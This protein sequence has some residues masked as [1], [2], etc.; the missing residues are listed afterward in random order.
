[1][2]NEQERVAYQEWAD[3]HPI[4]YA[5]IEYD[6]FIAGYQAGR[7]ALQSQYQEDAERYRY[8]VTKLQQA[9]DG[10]YIEIGPMSLYCY[11]QSQFKGDRVIRAEITWGDE[12]GESIGLSEAIDHAKRI[13]E[14]EADRQRRGEP[15]A[16][17]VRVGREEGRLAKRPYQTGDN[18]PAVGSYCLISGANCDIESDQHRGYFW[19][20]VLGYSDDREFVCLQTSGCWPTVERLTKCWFADIPHPMGG[21]PQPAEPLHITHGPLMRHAASLLR[22]RQPVPS[23]F[24]RVAAELEAAID[25]HPTPAGEPS[26]E[27]LSIAEKAEHDHFRDAAKMVAPQP[28]EPVKCLDPSM[29][30]HACSN[31]ARCWEPCGELGKSIDH[32]KVAEPVNTHTDDDAVDQFAVV[33]KAKLA[34]ARAKGRHGWHEC[35]PA[36]LSAM[37]REHVEKGDPRDVANFCMFLWSLGQP[38][39]AAPVAQEPV[40]RVNDEGFIVE[41]G[42]PLAP[43]TSLYAAPVAAQPTIA[44]VPAATVSRK[45]GS[46]GSLVWT[47]AGR[48]ADLPDGTTLYMGHSA[49]ATQPSTDEDAYVIDRMSK[50]LA[51]IAVIV[52]GPEVPR[53][54]HG[55]ADL[56]ERV[57]ALKAASVVAQ[58][59]HSEQDLNMVAAQSSVLVPDGWKLVPIEATDEMILAFWLTWKAWGGDGISDNRVCAGYQEMLAAAPTPATSRGF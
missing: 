56:P 33:M 27:W 58:S 2:N 35:D 11:T 31:R 38:I 54:R 49:V 15:V 4:A 18:L 43:G 36:D 5:G 12:T 14:M 59:D 6:A 3:L 25:G 22:L 28:A 26:Q 24:E 1:M 17:P 42:I 41:T 30:E 48:M 32:A 23:G 9:Y 47:E 29:S 16:Y 19:R 7:A 53:H 40:A 45:G 39:S 57:A 21:A 46:I 10:D 55:Y 44:R 8:L 13:A 50:L 34:Q 52:R 37:L 51:E 20:Q